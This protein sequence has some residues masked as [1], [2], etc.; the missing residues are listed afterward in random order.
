MKPTALLLP[1]ACAAVAAAAPSV[2][3]A[4]LPDGHELV[5]AAA[6]PLVKH[7]MM[8]GLDDRGRLFVAD[9]AGVNQTPAQLEKDPPHR[10]VLLEDTDGD[11]VYDKSTVF[12]DKVVFPQG[13][14]WHQGS[15]YVASP[16]GI[17]KFTDTDGDGVADRREMI[18]GGFE[19]TGN[20][21]DV[22][23][24]FLHPTNGRLYWCHGRKGHKVVR[25]DGSLVHEGKAAGIWSCLPDG[26]DASRAS[27]KARMNER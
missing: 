1:L 8:A 15:L 16:P 14:L 9:S 6:P 25:K 2:P 23:G 3:K 7:P 26:G 17:W 18:V 11:Q 19:Y 5:L 12:A 21:A 24:P 22:H 13:A 10:I 20:A 27:M 4:D